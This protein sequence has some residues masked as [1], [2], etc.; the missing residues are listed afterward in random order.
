ME[1]CLSCGSGILPGEGV[2]FKCP[3]CGNELVRCK[4]CRGL[5]TDYTCP[6]CGFRG[7]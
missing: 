6:K 1:K 2:V 7:P 3:S 4:S 5:A